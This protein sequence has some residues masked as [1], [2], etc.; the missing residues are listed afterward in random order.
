MIVTV[1]PNPLQSYFSETVRPMLDQT[2]ILMEQI[3][4]LTRARDLLL[5]RL[6]NGEI[7]V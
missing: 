4:R 2:D 6:M 1:P 5:P 7:A 3:E